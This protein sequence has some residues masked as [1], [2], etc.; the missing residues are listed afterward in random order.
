MEFAVP[1]QALVR[2]EY[3]VRLLSYPAVLA[4]CGFQSLLGS[5]DA[6]ELLVGLPREHLSFRM[7]RRKIREVRA[8]LFED[9]KSF[10]LTN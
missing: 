10:E 9:D 2:A 6:R 5:L 3:T 7:G 8:A 1:A 4:R